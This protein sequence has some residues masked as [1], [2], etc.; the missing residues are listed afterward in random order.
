[1]RLAVFNVALGITVSGC[2]L[3]FDQQPAGACYI[4]V[5]GH[6]RCFAD[7]QALSADVRRETL[8]AAMDSERRAALRAQSVV[9]ERDAQE[10]AARAKATVERSDQIQDD[11]F[12]VLVEIREDARERA[13]QVATQQ[14][15]P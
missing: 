15:A 7:E 4:P 9:A 14:T 6:R 10:A 5:D 3:A 12:D 1:M 11:A 2:G 8:A 13:A